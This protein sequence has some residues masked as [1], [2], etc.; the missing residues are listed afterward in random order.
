MTSAKAWRGIEPLHSTRADVERLLGA[1][2]SKEK[3]SIY[4][5]PEERALI[6]YSVRRCEE[7]L[8]GGWNVPT[9]TV[10]EIYTMPSA[11]K[12]VEE[13]LVPGK[14]YQQTRAAHTLQVYYLDPDEGI[15][16]TVFDGL[17]RS[18]SFLPSAREQNLSCGDYKYAA[19]VPEGAKLDRVELATFD[20]FGNISFEDAK[21]RLDNFVIQLFSL[22]EQDSRWRGYIIVY[23]GARAYEG[24]AQFRADCA[25]NYLVKVRKMEV[26]SLYAVDGGFR[27][28]FQVDLFLGRSDYYPAVLTPTVSPRKVKIIN[29]QLRS[30]EQWNPSIAAPNKRLERTRR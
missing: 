30:C 18:I 17:V 11:E 12:K 9:D 8:P 27:E 16:Y 28:E 19:P 15:S 13:V 22:K 5:F 6:F 3:I 2:K 29:R 1:P 25:K 24:E 10:V 26:S 7:G 21:A 20:S 14:Q 4:D 23:A